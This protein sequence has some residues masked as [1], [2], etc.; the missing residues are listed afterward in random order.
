MI[1]APSAARRLHRSILLRVFVASIPSGLVGGYVFAKFTG[2]VGHEVQRALYWAAPIYVITAALQW[3]IVERLVHRALAEPPKDEPGRRLHALLKLPR[4]VE[5]LGNVVGWLVGGV[6]FGLALHF[7]FGREWAHVGYAGLVAVLAALFPGIVLSLSV[8]NLVRPLALEEFTRS[9]DHA[10]GPRGVF[11]TRQRIYL[12]YAF[13]AALGSMVVFSGMLVWAEFSRLVEG[14][15]AGLDKFGLAG[16]SSV[17]QLVLRD[18]ARQAIAPVFVVA[19]VFMVAFAVTGF[20]MARRLS[21]AA[22]EVEAALAGMVAGAP[23]IPRWVATDEIGDLSTATA[24]IALQMQDVFEQLRAM[25][26]GDLDRELHGESA[27]LQAFQESRNAMRELERRMIALSRGETVDGSR[28][29]GDLGEAFARLQESLQGIAEQAQTIAAGDLRRDVDVPGTLGA[30]IQRMTGNLRVMV[31]RTQSVSADVGD[32]VVSLQSASAQLSAATTEQVAAVTE[33]ANTMTEMAQT[34]AVSADRAGELIR[35]GDAASAVVEEGSAAAEAAVGAMSAISGS[36]AKV[37]Q[38]SGALAERVQKIDSITETV[39]FLSDQSSTLAIN[40]AIEAA[41]AGEAGKGFSVVAR[42]IRSLAADSR[43]AAAEIREI[44]GEIRDRTSQVDGSVTA[45]ARTVDEGA[46]LV[47]RMGEVVAQLG[48]TVHDSVGLMR[49]VEG[50][51]RQHQAGVAQVSQALTNLQRASESIRDGA[52][53]LG[54]LSGRAH[55]L[56]EGLQGAAGAY[57]LSTGKEATT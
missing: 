54:D 50:S 24:R 39:S 16:V 57:V 41:R 37:A 42:E 7:F 17:V 28:I 32:I 13:V 40:A 8:E 9:P 18:L 53:L 56:S 19:L 44:L 14:V 43:K 4:K 35:Q 21:R 23:A 11:W 55:E 30:S 34:S 27:L 26:S 22:A 31:G 25:A 48:I 15:P 46:R 52:R 47:Q 36:L 33:T 1:A 38:A 29:P 10:L 49:Q 12:P 51:A 3:F 2:L 45:G 6:L 20:A 5:L